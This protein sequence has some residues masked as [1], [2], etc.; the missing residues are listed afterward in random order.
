MKE[1]ANGKLTRDSRA[2]R[3]DMPKRIL[4]RN[5]AYYE[6]NV[7]ESAERA[8]MRNIGPLRDHFLSLLRP[9]ARILDAGCGTGRDALAFASRGCLVTAFDAS[10]AMVAF[11]RARC[12]SARLM[13]FHQSRWRHAFDGIWAC[14]SLLHLPRSHIESGLQRLLNALKN[15]GMIFISLREGDGE[16]Y[17]SDG[18]YA[19]FYSVRQVRR[20]LESFKGVSIVRL[21]RSFPDK[22]KFP[23]WINCLARKQ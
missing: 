9:R 3:R 11:C 4:T 1:N 17:A 22:A 16:G 21:W 14:A 13:T 23:V 12:V 18:R 2:L 10:P 5:R 15:G 7:L 20:L 8:E 19:T 6:R